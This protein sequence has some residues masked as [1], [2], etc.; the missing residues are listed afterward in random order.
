MLPPSRVMRVGNIPTKVLVLPFYGEFGWF[1]CSAIRYVHNLVADEKIVCCRP[2]EEIFFPTATGF[3]HNYVVK[4]HL[5]K[6]LGGWLCGQNRTKN[7]D[8]IYKENPH[9]RD[10]EVIQSCSKLDCF[11]DFKQVYSFFDTKHEPIDTEIDI[12]ISARNIAQASGKNWQEWPNV[13]HHLHTLGL[14]VGAVGSPHASFDMRCVDERA[15]DHV[16]Y[17]NAS[18]A[19][20]KKAKLV[21]TTNTGIAHLSI[22]LRRPTLVLDATGG[23]MMCWI[24]AQRDLDV[25]YGQLQLPST[26]KHI[27]A[28]IKNYLLKLHII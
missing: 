20:L 10:H 9:L 22:F 5:T 18:I 27:L 16:D 26:R 14:K 4:Q 3:V 11:N 21:I 17:N 7:L 24:D 6:G 19:I 25:F 13:V 23:E 1:I 28:V 8:L 12:A 15:W 2:D